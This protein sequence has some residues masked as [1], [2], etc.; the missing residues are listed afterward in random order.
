MV[1]QN[2]RDPVSTF[3][4]VLVL[5]GPWPRFTTGLSELQRAL[6]FPPDLSDS[7]SP[8]SVFSLSSLSSFLSSVGAL[9]WAGASWAEIRSRRKSAPPA[10]SASGFF[11]LSC[12]LWSSTVTSRDSKQVHFG[13]KKTFPCHSSPHLLL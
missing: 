10:F 13:E 9:F 11:M 1:R 12:L 7:V 6:R 8:S 2:P 4:S 3:S 5:R